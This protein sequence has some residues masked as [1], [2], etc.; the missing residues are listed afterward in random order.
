MSNETAWDSFNKAISAAEY[1]K[2]NML[3]GNAGAL[4]NSYRGGY[5]PGLGQGQVFG[6][7]SAHLPTTPAHT[8]EEMIRDLL[9][10]AS[11]QA[12]TS[13]GHVSAPTFDQHR[14]LVKEL[15]QDFEE[16]A[17]YIQAQMNMVE[18]AYKEKPELRRRLMRA[19][20]TA[21]HSLVHS[22]FGD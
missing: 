13:M 16:G 18:S 19:L 11:K 17:S 1:Q 7:M 14:A 9:A 6:Q 22:T 21:Y 3:G 10:R 8:K 5:G 2:M 4:D 12:V 20:S 15:L